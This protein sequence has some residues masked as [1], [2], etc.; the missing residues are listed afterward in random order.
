MKDLKELSHH[1]LVEK[2]RIRV[3]GKGNLW[4]AMEESSFSVVTQETQHWFLFDSSS[5]IF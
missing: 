3:I 5:S 1:V 4:E 2:D